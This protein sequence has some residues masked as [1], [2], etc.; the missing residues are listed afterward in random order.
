M[1]AADDPK[2]ASPL[3]RA[4]VTLAAEAIRGG[5]SGKRW[6]PSLFLTAPQTP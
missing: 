6:K 5:E 3:A 1:V 4:D 2:D